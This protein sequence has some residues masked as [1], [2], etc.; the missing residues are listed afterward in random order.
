MDF[1]RVIT[2][3]RSVRDFD[4]TPIE[5]GVLLRCIDLAS[6]SPSAGKAQGWDLIVWEGDETIRYW[7][8][9]LPPARRATFGWPGLLRAPLVALVCADPRVYLARYSEPDK[10]STGWGDSPAAWPAPYWSVDASFATMAFLLALEN[11]GYGS[12]FFAH[13]HESTLRERLAIPDDIVILGVVAAGR[14]ASSP[15][16]PGRSA[17]RPRRTAESIIHRGQW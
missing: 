16:R 14:A 3:R 7:D 10:S 2:G 13:T 1:D 6:R 11:E 4:S 15:R 5:P 8:I 17:G 9:A 12:L